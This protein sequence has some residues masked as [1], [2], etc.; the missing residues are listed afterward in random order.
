MLDSVMFGSSFLVCNQQLWAILCH[1]LIVFAVVM[2][3]VIV[4]VLVFGVYFRLEKE[5]Q[6]CT[7]LCDLLCVPEMVSIVCVSCG[8]DT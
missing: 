2:A 4:T 6:C 8:R 7:L 5:L 3:V 1:C